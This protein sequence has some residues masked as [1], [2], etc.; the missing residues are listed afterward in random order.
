MPSDNEKF[1]EHAS[2]AVIGDSSRKRFP[3]LTYGNLKR[4]GK[5]VYAV[6]LGGAPTVEGD[7]AY[8]SLADLPETVQATIVEVPRRDT[9]DVVRRVADAGIGN[10]WLHQLSDTPEALALCRER[11]LQVR[12]GTCAVMYTGGGSYHRIHRLIAKA[13]RKF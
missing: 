2:F 4:L 1:F 12:H 9:L 8:R 6:D 11:G 10:V 7:R 3:K 5:K 13:A